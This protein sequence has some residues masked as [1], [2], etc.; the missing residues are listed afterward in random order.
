VTANPFDSTG[1][2]K[3]YAQ[4]RHFWMPVAYSADLTD[5][6]LGTVLFGERLVAARLGG[7]IVVWDDLCRHRGTALSLGWVE[8]N[9]LRCAYHGWT[10]DDTGT[11]CDI[12]ARPEL[13]GKLKVTI[14]S[15][16][17]AEAA[18]L[19]WTCLDQEPR[20]P[21]PEF[22]ELDD[23]N[24]R[25]ISIEPYE[26]HCSVGRRLENLFDFSHFAF[27]HHGILGDRDQAYIP[28]YD[29]SRDGAELRIVAGPFLEY[30]DNVKNKVA[31]VET[32]AETYEAWKR[33][34]VFIP[35]AMKLNSSAGPRGEDYV[36][37]NAVAPVGPKTTRVFTFVARNYEFD[38]DDRFRDFVRLIVGQDG[39]VVQSQRPEELPEDL[40]EE[41]HVKGA[42]LGTLEYRRWLLDIANGKIEMSATPTPV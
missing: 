17:V 21:V 39:P 1:E 30:T 5:R 16:P 26:W 37:F 9:R 25:T 11:V 31:G 6:P 42:D 19:V 2:T 24:Y 22:P 12:P 27:V 8:G 13:S 34:R 32:A 33:Y 20:F 28:D 18:G 36:L 15:Y 14:P 40:S 35:N 4:L 23:P 10:Y 38:E 29:V 3:L 7:K 41:L